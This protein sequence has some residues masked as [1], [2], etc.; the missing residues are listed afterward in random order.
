MYLGNI[1]VFGR[2]IEELIERLELVL[3]CLEDWFK[4]ETLQV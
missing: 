1:V 4:A 3:R 2:T